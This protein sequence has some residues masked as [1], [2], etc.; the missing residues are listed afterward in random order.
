[1]TAAVLAGLS[2]G[3]AAGLAP[4]PLQALIVTS[5]LRRGFGAGWRVAVA[6]LLTDAV[7]VAVSVALL[8]ALP[9]RFLTALGIA[10]GLV[11]IGLGVAEIVRSRRPAEDDEE[12]RGSASDV[13]AGAV[14]NITNPHPWI[15]WIAAGGPLVVRLWRAEPV[16]ALA[17]LV[18]FY[19][20]L[21]GAKVAIA[22]AV[23][24]VRHRLGARWR[25]RLL[26]A[27]GILLVAGGTLLV[28][29]IGGV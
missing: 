20:T 14:V 8:A 26:A 27:G 23:A 4:G 17:F 29:G 19:A 25:R 1:V 2:L 9:D 10:G 24:A 3:L 16:L 22:G 28:L 7:I 11:I 15:F 6:P 13:A 18:P 21:V 5:T 12:G